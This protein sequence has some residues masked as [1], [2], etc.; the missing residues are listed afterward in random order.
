MSD[1]SVMSV[2]SD[3][4]G[5]PKEE[6]TSVFKR[7]TKCFDEL[8]ISTQTVIADTKIIMDIDQ[9]FHNIPVEMSSLTVN[10]DP[11]IDPTSMEQ[12]NETEENNTKKKKNKFKKKKVLDVY[13]GN[14][15]DDQIDRDMCDNEK[16]RKNEMEMEEWV[17][18]IPHVYCRAMYYKNDIKIDPKFPLKHRERYFR[19]ALNVVLSLGNKCINFKLSKNGKFQ[20]TGC[21]FLWHAQVSVVAFI[22]MIRKYCPNIA[23]IHQRVEA[24]PITFQTVMTNVDFN[25]GFTINREKLDQLMNDT[26]SFYSLLETSF[27]YTGVNIKFPLPKE[28]WKVLEVPRVLI[29]WNGT[30]KE[31]PVVE[32]CDK[33]VYDTVLQPSD[34]QRLGV[35][36][37]FN[38]FLVFHSG[39]VIMSGMSPQLMTPDY[40]SFCKLLEQWAPEIKEKIH[41]SSSLS[42]STS[43]STSTKKTLSKKSKKVKS[44]Q[45]SVK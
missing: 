29:H 18:L 16:Y 11:S 41:S 42:T 2:M 10:H 34:R 21:K 30:D 40:T 1:M 19:N 32:G 28:W 39:N 14:E 6:E 15:E 43:T 22:G 8:I 33:V 27:G 36:N 25:T 38:T 7:T 17:S 24:L 37:K 45:D 35:K 26:T 13:P 5:T 4:S 12:G 9:C 23:G 20:L 31:Y 3:M 44:D